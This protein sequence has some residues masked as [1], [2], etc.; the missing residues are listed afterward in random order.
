MDPYNYP[1]YMAS[2]RRQ[3]RLPYFYE[4]GSWRHIID[5]GKL[6]VRIFSKQF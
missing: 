2:W 4:Y 3:G 5:R 1:P 6:K